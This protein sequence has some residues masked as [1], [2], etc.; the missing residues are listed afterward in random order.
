MSDTTTIQIDVRQALLD[1]GNL[2]ADLVGIRA[3]MARVQQAGKDVFGTAALDAVKIANEIESVRSEY[4]N[5]SIRRT[6]LRGWRRQ[7][8]I[9]KRRLRPWA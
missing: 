1:I 3:E 5:I 9:L 8:L 7:W 4:K 6:H 2:K